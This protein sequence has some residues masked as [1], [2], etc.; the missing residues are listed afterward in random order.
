[1]DIDKVFVDDQDKAKLM[2]RERKVHYY[3]HLFKATGSPVQDAEAG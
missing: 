1:M 2:P 3:E